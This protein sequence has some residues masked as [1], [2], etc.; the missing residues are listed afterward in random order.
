[1]DIVF[2]KKTLKNFGLTMAVAL[3]VIFA[4]VFFFHKHINYWLLAISLIF[5]VLAVVCPFV[6][7]PVYILWMKL[8]KILSWINTRILLIIM[9][10]LIFTPIGIMIRLL[11]KDLLER[12]IDKNS[13]TYWKKKEKGEFT[14]ESYL[15]QF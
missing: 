15:H 1:M 14:P 12:K 7:K 8:A 4:L 5:L 3:A 13:K 2:D 9:F 6:L 11:G 10:Y